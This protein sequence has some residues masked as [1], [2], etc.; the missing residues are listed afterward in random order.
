[1]RNEKDEPWKESLPEGICGD[2]DEDED[3]DFDNRPRHPL[4]QRAFALMLRLHGLLGSGKEGKPGSEGTV[5]GSHESVLLHGAGE[6]MGG[7]AQAFSSD[8]F[9]PLVGLSVV[10]LKRA[11]R[12]AAFAMGALHPLRTSGTLDKAAFDEIHDTI[13]ALQ[14]DIYAELARLRQRGKDDF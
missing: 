5:A 10:Q 8:D 3:G 7:L 9:E 13:E 12:G 1:M 11:L 4:Q 14:T 2:E 6:I